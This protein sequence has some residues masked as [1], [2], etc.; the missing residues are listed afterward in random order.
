MGTGEMALLDSRWNTIP[1]K[2][3]AHPR[4]LTCIKWRNEWQVLTGARG[5]DSSIRLW[6]LRYVD[7]D[8]PALN[9]DIMDYTGT[10]LDAS[11]MFMR[12]VETHQKIEFD[13]LGNDKLITG[14]PD[15]N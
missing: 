1:V 2:V 4:G 13:F 9:F 12:K 10:K 5:R 14:L 11:Y 8:N 6:D 7:K 15:G 3:L